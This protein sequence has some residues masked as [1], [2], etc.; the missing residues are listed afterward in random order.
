[1]HRNADMVALGADVCLAFIRDASPGATHAARL[2]EQ[3]GIPVRRFETSTSHVAQPGSHGQAAPSHRERT[4]AGDAS[5]AVAAIASAARCTGRGTTS[6]SGTGARRTSTRTRS[7][8]GAG[9]PAGAE[10]P[11]RG[12]L[13]ARPGRRLPGRPRRGRH[14]HARRPG[15]RRMAGAAAGPGRVVHRPAGTVHRGVRAMPPLRAPDRRRPRPAA[16]PV[17][18]LRLPVRWHT[19]DLPARTSR[20]RQPPSGSDS[21]AVPGQPGRL[22][23]A[24]DEDDDEA[25]AQAGITGQ[26]LREAAHRY[27]ED[28]LLPVPAWAARPD[29]ECCCPRGADCDAAGQASPLG[30][31]RP[32]PARLLVEAAGLPHPRRGRP[33][34]RPRRPVRG[35][36]PDGRD[37]RR[38]DGHRHRRRRRRTRRGRRAGRRARGAAADPGAPHPAR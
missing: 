36:E 8:P 5:R 37:P 11:A 9:T 1:M 21:A 35:R 14:S 7:G 25:S 33:A 38:D 17:P 27:L 26:Q 23:T 31:H 24:R 34:V 29:G 10:P 2:A 3:A 16:A 18:G 22:P 30:P 6:P 32:R 19:A 13:P 28:G 20:F 4:P 12:P 15:P